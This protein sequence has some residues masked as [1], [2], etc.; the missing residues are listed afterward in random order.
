MNADEGAYQLRHLYDHLI[1]RVPSDDDVTKTRSDQRSQQ[2]EKA[3]CYRMR[4]VTTKNS[5]S[6]FFKR[7]IKTINL[8]K[9]TLY[10]NMI[11]IILSTLGEN[12]YLTK[13]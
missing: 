7:T 11:K 8:F 13:G 10:I 9:H 4:N 3:S 2:F 1:N 5:T 12:D 6:G